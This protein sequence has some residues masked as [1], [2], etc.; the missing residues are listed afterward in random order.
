M[1]VEKLNAVFDGPGV[2]DKVAGLRR[3]WEVVRQG[4]GFYEGKVERLARELESINKGD[5]WVGD[6]EH[7]EGEEDSVGRE[8]KVDVTDEDL[9]R[10]EEEIKELE[11]KKAELEERVSGMERDLG[12]LLR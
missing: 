11:R 8:F 3:R 9:R 1:G 10:E 4:L 6:D 2:Q 7:D 12:G 5:E